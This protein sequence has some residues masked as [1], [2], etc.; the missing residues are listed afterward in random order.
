MISRETVEAAVK[1]DGMRRPTDG[2]PRTRILAG[3]KFD[4]EATAQ[5]AGIDECYAAE[6][7]NGRITGLTT[8]PSNSVLKHELELDL[9]LS[10]H[11]S[12]SVELDDEFPV[13]S[14]ELETPRIDP[15]YRHTRAL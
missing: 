7:T 3:R 8:H 5:L 13:V 10:G 4:V 9:R 2:L 14:T 15:P 12:S 1:N 11:L 6:S